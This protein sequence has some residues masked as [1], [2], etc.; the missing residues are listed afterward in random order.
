MHA[1][2]AR[3][4]RICGC[5]A[6]TV[7]RMDGSYPHDIHPEYPVATVYAD[8]GSPLDYVAS[9]EPALSYAAR[10]YR[11]KVHCADGP[12]SHEELQEAVDHELA[13]AR[14]AAIGA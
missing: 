7:R 8:D 12:Y 13:G 10:G 11:V 1:A 3:R 9:H 6:P 14:G 5:G 4:G 2:Q